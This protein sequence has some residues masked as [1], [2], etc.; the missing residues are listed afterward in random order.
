M[1]ELPSQIP[2]HATLALLVLLAVVN[3]ITHWR[4]SRAIG[5]VERSLRPPPPTARLAIC[6]C[7][8]ARSV[9]IASVHTSSEAIGC[10]VCECE[11][12]ELA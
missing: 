7:G 1:I 4:A 5:R 10:G 6:K 2:D 9:H 3:L 11:C 12:Y 8:H